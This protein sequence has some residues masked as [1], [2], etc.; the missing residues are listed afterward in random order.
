MRINLVSAQKATPQIV[1][2]KISPNF[3]TAVK[4]VHF[5]LLDESVTI[6]ANSNFG[7]ARWVIRNPG[8]PAVPNTTVQVIF[9]LAGNSEVQVSENFKYVGWLITQ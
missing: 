4:G 2:V 3:S 7:I 6:P 8:A 1:T 5:D 9:E